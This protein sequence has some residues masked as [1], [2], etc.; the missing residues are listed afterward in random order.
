[1]AKDQQ[2][3]NLARNIEYLTVT[4][5]EKSAILNINYQSKSQPGLYCQWIPND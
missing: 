3:F 2:D 1:L 4:C 5:D